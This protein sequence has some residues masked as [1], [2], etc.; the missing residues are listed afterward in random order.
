[1]GVINEESIARIVKLPEDESTAA[2][3]VYG[4]EEGHPQPTPRLEVDE[5][6]RFI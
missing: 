5:I 2:L 3:I 4:Y 6:V 1:M